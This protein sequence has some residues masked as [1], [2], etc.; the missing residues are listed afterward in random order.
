LHPVPAEL[1]F[2]GCPSKK[3]PYNPLSKPELI[4]L[5]RQQLY[6]YIY[7]IY[8]NTTL[9]ISGFPVRSKFLRWRHY[10]LRLNLTF[11]FYVS[12]ILRF[13]YIF[14]SLK[15]YIEVGIATEY[16]I[17]YNILLLLVKYYATTVLFVARRYRICVS[18]RKCGLR[19][20]LNVYYV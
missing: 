8:N 11:W 1:I 18:S 5:T 2:C 10:F 13:I 6:I 7:I 17:I 16:I 19:Y 12:I 14:I 4:I 9:F 3:K 15:S 20:I